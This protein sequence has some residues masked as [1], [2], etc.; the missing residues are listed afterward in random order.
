MII[1]KGNEKIKN[2][3][4]FVYSL[5]LKKN[6]KLHDIFEVVLKFTY[7]IVSIILFMTINLFFFLRNNKRI[8]T[9]TNNAR[10]HQ[11]EDMA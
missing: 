9:A 6:K 4:D 3:L 2:N 5:P 1:K 8:L 7:K 11:Q 10:N